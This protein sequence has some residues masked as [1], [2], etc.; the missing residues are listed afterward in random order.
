MIQN[1]A[2]HQALHQHALAIFDDLRQIRRHLHQFPELSGDEA[3]TTAF[4]L[5][6]LQGLGLVFKKNLDGHGF[7]ADLVSDPNKETVVLRVDIDALPIQELNEV[8]YRSQIPGVMHAC[9]HDVHS[10]I[11][12]GVA[13]VLAELKETLPLNIRII[14]QPEEEEISG[15]LSMIRAGSLKKPVSKAIWGVHVA[16][17]QSGKIAWTNDLFLSGFEHYLGV[18]SQ[19][20]GN[21]LPGELLERVAHEC[22]NAIHALNRWHLPETWGEMQTFWQT[23]QNGPPELKQFI[24]YDASVNTED[25]ELW[26]GQFGIGIKAATPARYA[27]AM[28][29]I[30]HQLDHICEGINLDYR[31]LPMGSMGDVRNNSTLMKTALPT[32][33]NAIGEANTI[34]LNAA[35]P[36][37]CEDFVYYTKNVPGAMVWLGGADPSSGKYAMLH[38]PNFD[39]DENC[40]LT[41]TIAMASLLLGTSSFS[42]E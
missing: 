31:I 2:L 16:P 27:D 42:R 18:L 7:F 35:F 20:G 40:L 6:K 11:G 13:R 3:N 26:Q 23:M 33:K 1:Y 29:A 37:N 34:K 39:V 22:C 25:P 38:T 12:V 4:L 28:A 9:G 41:G 14:F 36:F 32:L 5:N 21:T 17:I 8:P 15:A 19:K 30:R 24:V 10:A